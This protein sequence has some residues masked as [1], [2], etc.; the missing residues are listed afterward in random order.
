MPDCHR[1]T[2][3][4]RG[5]SIKVACTS[6]EHT[7][8]DLLKGYE[9]C[10]L[11]DSDFILLQKLRRKFPQYPIGIPSDRFQDRVSDFAPS[12][13]KIFA[14]IGAKNNFDW[15]WSGQIASRSSTA[16]PATL[17]CV[18]LML[19]DEVMSEGKGDVLFITNSYGLQESIARAAK[20]RKIAYECQ[21]RG[22]CLARLRCLL[23]IV[24]R[25]ISYLLVNRRWFRTLRR[26]GIKRSLPMK[27]S[28]LFRVWITDN[29]IIPEKPYFDRNFGD[30]PSYLSRNGYSVVLLPM[31][32][33]LKKDLA[34]QLMIMAKSG[35][36]FIYP[37]QWITWS[38]IVKIAG[39]EWRRLR[40]SFRDV[41]LNGLDVEP[42]LRWDRD[43]G[44]CS[45]EMMLFNLA[46]P[47]L[48]RLNDRGCSFAGFLAAFENK[49]PEKSFLLAARKVYSNVPFVGYLHTVWVNNDFAHHLVPEDLISYPL[50]DWIVT[51]GDAYLDILED[52]GFP[53]SCLKSGPA[54]RFDYIA[55][56]K[57]V[58]HA[59]PPEPLE[60]FFP[61]PYDTA[62]SLEVI[63]RIAAALEGDVDF[64]LI[65]K[66][67][68]L[69]HRDILHKELER[70]EDSVIL[71]DG[72]CSDWYPKC[73]LV[74]ACGASVI[75]FEAIASGVPLV[76]IAPSSQFFLDP[77]H[78][79]TYP[80]PVAY[81]ADSIKAC[82]VTALEI[83]SAQL[84]LLASEVGQ[85][86]KRPN[87]DNCKL[88]ASLLLDVDKIT[89]STPLQ[90]STD[91]Q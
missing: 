26:L 12:I 8:E 62:I 33:N 70:F 58:E 85:Y 76:R 2:L 86:F 90:N 44:A 80:V 74:L 31:I 83:P 23:G 88:F 53:G 61:L 21:M 79:M 10:I 16:V 68:P 36:D 55:Q 18:Y 60:I 67:H 71:V 43:R 64:H 66:P 42:I 82:V 7:T 89:H 51:P 45:V 46:H 19:A 40:V 37:H 27:M 29:T 11:L 87:E 25:T 39:W 9:R 56:M 30:M 75:Q 14:G 47:L 34:D 57:P 1:E 24:R 77:M 69:N 3:Q 35:V 20:K 73:H 4:R 63:T 54:F 84:A 6:I 50:P 81:D 48:S 15:W 72:S 49:G 52:T 22:R 91:Q 13:M 78:W 28:V 59:L 65:V 32:F 41:R 38:D 5:R 17:E